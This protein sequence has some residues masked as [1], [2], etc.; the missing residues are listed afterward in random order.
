MRRALILGGIVAA[1]VGTG[2][3]RANPAYCDADTPCPNGGSCDPVLNTCSPGDGGVEAG[4]ADAGGD[5]RTD[6]G[7]AGPECTES[8]QCLDPARPICLGT[9]CAA[10]TGDDQ[11]LARDA[12][13]PAC[14]SGTCY[15][16]STY[17]H[18]SGDTPICA[19]DHT[20]RA[21]TR[22]LE[23]QAGPT[24]GVGVCAAGACPDV[25]DVLWVDAT[26]GGCP[27][28]GSQAAPFCTLVDATTAAKT[29]ARKTLVV[30]AGAYAYVA[31]KDNGLDG[32]VV[33]GAPGGGDVVIQGDLSHPAV[34]IDLIGAVTLRRLHLKGGGAGGGM[35]AVLQ[36]SSAACTCEDLEVEAGGL[37]VVA[38]AALP[39]TLR[40]SRV[41]GNAAGGLVLGG[42][43]SYDIENN[44]VYSNG[45][46]SA[47]MGGVTFAAS[48]QT[49]RFV[50][51]SVFANRA[52][53]GVTA[54]VTCDVGTILTSNNILWDNRNGT[55]LAEV[56]KPGGIPVCAITYSVTDDAD[57]AGATGAHNWS[58]S[59]AFVSSIVP[60]FDL[61]LTDGSG[62][63]LGGADPTA[64][65]G[66]DIDGQSRPPGGP[67]DI[68]ADQRSQ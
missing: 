42:S 36:C 8:S 41:H 67:T 12:T 53:A 68:G 44:F 52:A 66:D 57:V 7:D 55:G 64:A 59:P 51:N 11:C 54:G 58:D 29:D 50:N 20:C 49:T 5:A 61:H 45:S 63:A 39:L 6:G 2:C 16:C 30:K 22:D 23:C 3:T 25:D 34:D 40:R 60:P 19:A 26:A 48:Y 9:A 15:A 27:G 4:R 31:L 17:L 24:P 28:I 35:T 33:A 18:C 65:P 37:G 10:C 43:S 32:L 62:H 47:S 56:N 14:L 1:L 46:L 21:C 38:N 13:T